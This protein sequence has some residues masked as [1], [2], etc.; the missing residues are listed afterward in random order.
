V[1]RSLVGLLLL[2]LALLVLD[3]F[4]NFWTFSVSFRKIAS[5]RYPGQGFP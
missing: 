5:C 1:F 3:R 2:L 4:T